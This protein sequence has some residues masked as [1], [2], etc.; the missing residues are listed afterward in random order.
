MRKINKLLIAKS[1]LSMRSL[2]YLDQFLPGLTQ[3]IDVKY[4]IDKNIINIDLSDIRKHLEKGSLIYNN[5]NKVLKY[6]NSKDEVRFNNEFN[7]FNKVKKESEIS[8][9]DATF[10]IEEN[11]DR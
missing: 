1:Y 10:T 4:N 7:N 3:D 2:Y 8:K 6:Y 9:I 5:I 11:E